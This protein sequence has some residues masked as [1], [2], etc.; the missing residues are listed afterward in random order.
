MIY[1]LK[2]FFEIIARTTI[3]NMVIKL[4]CCRCVTTWDKSNR[5]VFLDWSILV[6]DVTDIGVVSTTDSAFSLTV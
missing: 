4:L 3:F 5:L 1:D 6:Y 2:S